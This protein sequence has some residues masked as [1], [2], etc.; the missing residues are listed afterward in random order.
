[1]SQLN[2]YRPDLADE[3]PRILSFAFYAPL[4][5]AERVMASLREARRRRESI[6]PFKKPEHKKLSLRLFDERFGR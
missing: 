5:R 1:M 6:L 3:E 2:V 4:I